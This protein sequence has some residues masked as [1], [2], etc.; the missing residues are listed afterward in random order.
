MKQRLSFWVRHRDAVTIAGTLA[1]ISVAFVVAYALRFDLALP[2]K[3]RPV[4]LALLPLLLACKLIAFWITGALRGSWS[5][6]SLR[7][8][9]D[10]VRGNLLGS[11][12]FLAAVVFAHGVG[13]FP[14]SVFLLD[15]LV[16]TGAMTGSRLGVR[17]VQ[18]RRA[19]TGV[20]RVETVA[21]IVGAG[22]AGIG[23]LQEIEARRRV[24]LGVVGFV[25]DDRAKVGLRVCG[26][27][28]LGTVDDLPALVARHDVGEVLIAIPSAS[29]ARLRRIVER[30]E[31]AR[32]K[33]R[34]LP[35]LAELIEGTV[36]YS[37]MR[38]VR[39]QDILA[40]E[41]VRLDLV[42]VRAL[43]GGK[44]VL[45][46]GAAGSIGSELCRQ[47]ALHGPATLVLYDRYENGV[48]TLEMELRR[49]HPELTVI[50]VLGDVLLPDQLRAVFTAHG[51]EIVFHA[52]AYKHVP[53][54]ERNV[55]EA[56]R[57]NILGTRNVLAAAI[58]H[59][60][61]EF[62]LV[63]TDKAVAPTSLM[64]ATKR[65]AEL[66]VQEARDGG[67]R[68]V[69][70]RFGNVLDS[71]GSVV[72]LFREQIA[73]GGP[74]TVTH[75]DV[76]RYFMTI[77][78]AT[79]LILQAA[80]LGSG[81]EI[82]ILD[83]GEPVRIVDLARQMIRLSGLRP[84]EDIAI[85]FTGLRPGEK[86][87]EELMTE[88][89]RQAATHHDRL[90]IVRAERTTAWSAGWHARLERAIGDGDVREALRLL[91]TVVP[92]YT[93]SD[94]AGGEPDAGGGRIV[95]RAGND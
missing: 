40:R 63:S 73:R 72:P 92:E 15:L 79:Q 50:P 49:R 28:V 61:R 53:L 44:P 52:A 24:R 76:T 5:H 31:E 20:R 19:R 13:G 95:A 57:N 62:V 88:R 10:I 64:G 83:M 30:C 70:V 77:P 55:L 59:R 1:L 34:V 94:V 16:C 89:E 38:E 82:F 3:H 54:T 35:T 84:D 43:L 91:C 93:P 11:T 87:Y 33:H 58:A 7:D 60:A 29:G 48:Y 12:L 2:A 85:T 17:L 81:G 21:L 22:S 80:A 67:C 47:I 90:S 71:S 69:A 32:V 23:L 66:L 6:V 56:V 18:E 46:T 8:L 78:E 25:D 39:V 65:A 51:P 41:P 9:E 4:L 42:R 45:V 68:A 14:R 75:P 27:P 74:V 36:M 86:L 37:Q 26:T